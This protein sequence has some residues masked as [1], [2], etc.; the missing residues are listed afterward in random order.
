MNTGFTSREAARDDL[1]KALRINNRQLST[2]EVRYL[3]KWLDMGIGAGA[4]AD[5]YDISII[6]TGRRSWAY[7]DTIIKKWYTE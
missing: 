3:D 6:R 2:A 4:I 5:A 7:I 1:K